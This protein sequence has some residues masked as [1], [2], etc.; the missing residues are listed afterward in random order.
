MLPEIRDRISSICPRPQFYIYLV[1]F[2]AA[3]V[4]RVWAITV[5]LNVDEVSW[6]RRGATFMR[7]LLAA[8]LDSTYERHHPG[9]TNM[10]LTGWAMAINCTLQQAFPGWFQLAEPFANFEKC[11]RYESY[12]I[13][14]FV[15]PRLLQALVT[16]AM[17]AGTYGLMRRL[18]DRSIALL[19]VGLLLF[20]PFFL[21]YQ[22]F[23]TTDA[24][25][26]DF[27]ALSLLWLLLY[28]RSSPN[29]FPLGLPTPTTKLFWLLASGVALGFAV[30]GKITILFILP[31]LS[32]VA[33]GIELGWW[34]NRFPPRGRLQWTIELTLW[35]AVG[36]ATVVLLW[37]MLW[38]EPWDTLTRLYEDLVDESARG[39]F[40]FLGQV[41][42]EV[43]GLFY[44]LVML[45]RLS[46]LFQ[47]GLVASVVQLAVPKW[48]RQ[49]P[50]T[51]DLAI[52]LV[53]SVSVLTV[54][55]MFSN[56]LDR[57]PLPIYPELAILSAVGWI[58]I[59]QSFKG[60]KRP[61]FLITGLLTV[62]FASLVPYAPEYVTYYNPI[63]DRVFA[64]EN[65]FSIGQGEGL[66][67]AAKWTNQEPQAEKMR[68][69]SWYRAV[70]QAYF[71]GEVLKIDRS[72]DPD[73]PPEWTRAHRVVLYA[74]QVQ[75]QFPT[76]EMVAYFQAQTPLHTVT[77]QN[78]E[79]A[80]IYP[81]P[82]PTET[83]RQQAIELS[84]P[85]SDGVVLRGTTALPPSIEAGQS[86]EITAFWQFLDRP[87][88]DLTVQIALGDLKEVKPLFGSCWFPQTIEPEAVLRD[89][90][91]LKI[92]DTPPGRYSIDLTL[93][94]NGR[95][96]GSSVE[97]GEID[98]KS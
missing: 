83:D 91:V 12:S 67:R 71:R 98:V 38:V 22:R 29:T 64:A 16:G 7:E 14:W 2:L 60:F 65:V 35:I 50:Y 89:V 45:Y 6:L 28:L 43:G 58:S 39:H 87:S 61:Q 57:Y 94:Q 44:P 36:G 1:I 69:A 86:L 20:E 53:L 79:Y 74:N 41:T 55:S 77:L 47:I 21:G 92:P 11:L 59:A 75:R 68:V 10:W 49:T 19:A 17:M 56:K 27:A 72:P 93:I 88:P 5:P 15:L 96:I 90:R 8:D 42:D 4:L 18:F 62:Q 26:V 95:P 48:R 66:E 37:P 81:G 32:I 63:F 82:V 33:V 31:G 23:L 34:K 9:V 97:I 73:T 52:L 25:M 78:R 30:A 40:F 70:F 84:R 54:F 85:A 3:V 24:L 13:S 51:P 80:W 46:P 76:P